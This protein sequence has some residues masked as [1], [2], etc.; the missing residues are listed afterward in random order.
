MENQDK[1]TDLKSLFEGKTICVT[2][3]LGSIGSMIVK[4]LI[5]YNPKKIIIID[6]RE[7]EIFYSGYYSNNKIIKSEFADIRDY[8]SINQIIKKVDIVFH[9]AAMKHVN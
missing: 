6:N 2:G 9:A 4:R 7:T 3:G 8:N 1:I 5:D